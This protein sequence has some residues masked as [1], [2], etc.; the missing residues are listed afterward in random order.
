MLSASCSCV[1]VTSARL[2][3]AGTIG[4]H[5]VSNRVCV[6]RSHIINRYPA[7]ARSACYLIDF[8]VARDCGYSI[9]LG[10]DALRIGIGF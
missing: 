9:V 6:G 4:H 7:N 2:C 10:Y 8:L 5:R 1:G 3:S